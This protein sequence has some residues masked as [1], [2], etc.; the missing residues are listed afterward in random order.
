MQLI[1][2]IAICTLSAVILFA[3]IAALIYKCMPTQVDPYRD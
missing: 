3:I 1:H 2:L